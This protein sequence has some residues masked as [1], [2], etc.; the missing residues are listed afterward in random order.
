VSTNV[1]VI[2][3]G[4]MGILHSG[5][6]NA[7]PSCRLKA[8]CEKE[9]LLVKTAKAFLLKTLP[10][11]ADY[12]DMLEREDLQAV[13][14]TTPIHTHV[15][16]IT[17]VAR[18]GRDISIFVEK[19]L[20]ATHKEAQ[21]AC[22][23]VRDWSGVHMVGYQKRFSPVFQ[24]AR[25]Y[26]DE[27]LLG[28]L[29]FFRAYSFSSDVLRRGSSWRFRRGTGGVLLDLAPHLLDI[30]LW[31]FGEPSSVGS[32]N[33][34]IFSDEVEDYVH[35]DLSYD[36][37]LKGTL[38]TCWCVRNFRLPE[39]SIE[40]YGEKGITTVSDDF[41]KLAL[42]GGL[43]NSKTLYRQ[44]F[45]NPVSFLLAD[46]EYT[47]EDEAFLKGL[48]GGSKPQSNFFEAAKVN[49]IIDRINENVQRTE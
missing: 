1:G 38:D 16:I 46:P 33:K 34:R 22:D 9:G 28:D 5:I 8:I 27:R 40:V 23:A 42:G 25:E 39:I 26:L 4:K 37:G 49:A 2:G 48:E 36:G 12:Q 11:Y 24:R 21:S 17:D 19:P 14:V 35:V 3:L 45:D 15:P 6:L 44:S 7:I 20:A 31:F 10:I 29:L 13:F 41:V 47:L 43:G 30:L 18:S 32:M